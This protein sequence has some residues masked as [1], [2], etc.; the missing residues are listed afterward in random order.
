M[1]SIAL[2]APVLL[3]LVAAGVITVFGLSGFNVG[4]FA[5]SAGVWAALLALLAIW[6]TV[7]STQELNLGPLGFGSR[8]DLRI[9][10][11]AFAF[12]LMV[13]VP[14]ALLLTLQTRTWADA[15]LGLLGVAAA[16]GAIVAR[17]GVVTSFAA[18]GGARRGDPLPAGLLSA[19]SGL[20]DGRRALSAPGFQRGAGVARGPGR[21]RSGGARPG[22]DHTTRISER[23]NSRSWWVRLDDARARHPAWCQRRTHRARDGGSDDRMPVPTSGSRR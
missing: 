19:C 6:L 21:T 8:L 13:L 3:P 9:D 17:A 15:T 2:L 11:V 4:P 5:A 23:G 1:P 22:R 10:A 18:S 12:G 14:S 7:R 16:M 20:R